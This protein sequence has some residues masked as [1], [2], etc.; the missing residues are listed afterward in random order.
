MIAALARVLAQRSPR[1]RLLLALL[2]LVALPVA[3]A[4]LVMLPLRDALIAGRADLAEAQAARAWYAERQIEIAA[5]PVAGVAPAL[6]TPVGLGGIE[7]R[8]IDAG[9]R[10]AVR[11]LAPAPGG[12]VSLGLDAAPFDVVMAWV[13]GIGA[14]GYRLAALSLEGAGDGDVT[15]EI[16]LEPRR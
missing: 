4:A 5:L 9:L 6:A 11:L 12:G 7:A 14:A 1:E 3:F 16:G 10:D 8:L 13:E 2:L 15:A